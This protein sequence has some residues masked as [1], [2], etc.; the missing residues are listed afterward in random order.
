LKTP[1]APRLTAALLVASLAGNAALLLR[2]SR[3]TAAAPSSSH[4]VPEPSSTDARARSS[5]TPA[6]SPELA[7]AFS[8]A[9]SA[10]SLTDFRALLEA[11][12]VEPALRREL[13]QTALTHRYKDRFRDTM[14]PYGELMRREW[15]RD[16]AIEEYHPA[17]ISA[18]RRQEDSLAVGKQFNAELSELLGEY[19]A[20]L[21]LEDPDNGWIAR[22][23]SGL[24]KEKAAALHRI[25]RD[26][27]ELE[28]EIHARSGNF[29]LPSDHAK[30]RL[31]KGEQERDIAALLTPEERA[32]WQLRVSPTADRARN[33]ST[34]YRATEEEYRRI[35]ALQKT[36][37][38]TF[39]P[40]PFAS[41]PFVPSGQQE[42]HDWKARQ[43]AEK[44]LEAGIRSIVGEER[45]AEALRRHS[46]DLTLA[47]AAVARLGLPPDAP[48]QVYSLREPTAEAS[49]RISS[50]PKLTSEEKKAA[51]AR[52]AEETRAKLAATLGQEASATYL[53]RGGMGWL[54]LLEQGMP[55]RFDPDHGGHGVYSP[56]ETEG[57]VPLIHID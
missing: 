40:D 36:F 26:Y 53:D 11:A 24:P 38:E 10:P 41:D 30:L 29:P 8:R 48:D 37:D 23:F 28:Q 43:E 1:A 9:L 32:E 6:A 5:A 12:G 19:L 20:A 21:D 49:R 31:L 2:A 46:S 35:Y 57:S 17:G 45:H 56:E 16:P 18:K 34:R 14:L 50:D 25:E 55:V 51:L 15:W 4:P 3:Q 42:D 22:R 7:A 27:Q 39:A 47:E 52:L 33:Y 13:L 44:A 54:R